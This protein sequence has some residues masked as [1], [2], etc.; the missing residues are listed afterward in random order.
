[1]KT[2]TLYGLR[3]CSTCVKARKWLDANGV[4]HDFVDY[5]DD[6]IADDVLAAWAAQHGW[7]TLINK[8]ST[9]WRGLS[10][11]QKTA[12]TD[13]QWLALVAEHPT[14]VKRPVLVKDQSVMF[15]FSDAKY[16]ELF[17]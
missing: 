13:E 6:P 1:M 14:L 4:E 12:G 17:K 10:D 5:R 9:S 3:R 16:A 15:G 11:E 8:A 2:V 7:A